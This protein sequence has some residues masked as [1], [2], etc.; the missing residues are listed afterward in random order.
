MLK[1]VERSPM[2][3]RSGF[4]QRA[5]RVWIALALVLIVSMSGVL[6]KT[7]GQSS[8]T[9]N[10]TYTL[11]T[12][13]NVGFQAQVTI[14]NTGPAINGWTVTWTFPGTQTIYELW[15]GILTQTGPNVTVRNQSYNA[16][17]PTGGS[18]NFGFNANWSG[19]NPN[20]TSF[21]L[22]GQTCGGSA[23]S[24]VTSVTTLNVNEGASAQFGVRLSA[25]PASNVTVSIARVSGDADL[26]VTSGASLTFTPANF[27]TQ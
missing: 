26:T 27:A 19:S 16:Q 20:P 4:P 10:I 22:N 17:I 5:F 9:C 21:T 8:S 13:W 2:S 18:V 1:P 24:I 6:R 23:P 25:A 15:N 12:Q 11:N 3:R 14:V 7:E